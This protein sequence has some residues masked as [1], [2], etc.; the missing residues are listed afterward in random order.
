MDN[1]IY[2]IIFLLLA[3]IFSV[4]TNYYNSK[5]LNSLEEAFYESYR[6]N[7]EVKSFIKE[8]LTEALEVEAIKRVR[9]KYGLSIRYAKK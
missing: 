7:D 2:I 6:N 1:S 8:V 3:L 4:I 5:K 9:T